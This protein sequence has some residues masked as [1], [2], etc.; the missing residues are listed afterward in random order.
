VLLVLSA[1]AVY[2]LDYRDVIDSHLQREADV[3]WSRP[4]STRTPAASAW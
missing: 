3:T 1:D 4:R 2:T